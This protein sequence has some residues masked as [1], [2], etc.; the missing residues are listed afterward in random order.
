M[1]AELDAPRLKSEQEAAWRK[2]GAC[3]SSC[4]PSLALAPLRGRAGSADIAWFFLQ[5]SLRN[6]A[7]NFRA[8]FDPEQ[9][10]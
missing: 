1:A 7:R 2:Y 10:I 8:E 3:L 9:G 6:L 4:D 5:N